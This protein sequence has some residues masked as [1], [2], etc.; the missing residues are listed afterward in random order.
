MYFLATFGI[1]VFLRKVIMNSI[2][3]QKSNTIRIS[4]VTHISH[5]NS[6]NKPAIGCHDDS[7]DMPG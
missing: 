2:Y 7:S 5:A 6:F 3:K 4:V 1:N